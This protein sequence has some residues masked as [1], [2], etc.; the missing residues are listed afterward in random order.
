M[1]VTASFMVARE[2]S[3]SLR[4]SKMTPFLSN[5]GSLV[6]GI[7]LSL[8]VFTITIAA[9]NPTAQDG[10]A[11]PPSQDCT[12]A[13][14]DLRSLTVQRAQIVVSSSNGSAGTGTDTHIGTGSVAFQLWNGATNVTAQC[15]GYGAQLAQPATTLSIACLRRRHA[16]ASAK[17]TVQRQ[18]P[19]DAIQG[20]DELVV[21]AAPAGEVYR[22][23]DG[24]DGGDGC[25][26]WFGCAF[27]M[28]IFGHT[29]SFLWSWDV[30]SGGHGGRLTVNE[31]W[32]CED[33]GSR[34]VQF[35]ALGEE[36][37]P[38]RCDDVW[39][40]QGVMQR[41]CHG[42]E[43]LEIPVTTATFVHYVDSSGSLM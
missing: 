33:D 11:L 18:S 40:D 39:L 42:P 32:V 20:S 19:P 8:V 21:D 1:D 28:P 35:E 37:L 12:S 36:E 22:K 2:S 29:A 25:G 38:L 41:K 23:D 27:E 30:A 4:G 16:W 9:T 6:Q 14:L 26:D 5:L 15:A 7:A 17:T 3:R 13:S 31:T 24:D 43:E 34:R 10:A